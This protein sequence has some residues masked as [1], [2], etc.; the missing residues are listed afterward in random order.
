LTLDE[1]DRLTPG[2][3]RELRR[4]WVSG[5]PFIQ[6]V[7]SLGGMAFFVCLL[8]V[9]L[10]SVITTGPTPSGPD[11]S[12]AAPVL[13]GPALLIALCAATIAL[14]APVQ[15]AFFADLRDSRL[16]TLTGRIDEKYVAKIEPVGLPPGSFNARARRAADLMT[17]WRVRIGEVL[18]DLDPQ[19]YDAVV[20]GQAYRISYL[21]RSHRIVRFEPVR[22][23]GREKTSENGDSSSVR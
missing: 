21:P 10:W 22:L 23:A 9:V 1:S 3:I 16:A 7:L 5:R 11:W 20:E 6:F 2:D 4:E 15:V 12:R 17:R 14:F 13:A 8:I 19:D 18:L